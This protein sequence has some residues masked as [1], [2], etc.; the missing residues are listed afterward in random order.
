MKTHLN[1]VM[2]KILLLMGILLI[3][4]PAY[5]LR[6]GTNLVE[7]GDSEA[8]VLHYCGKP[9]MKTKIKKKVMLDGNR[10][11]IT[12]IIQWTYNFGSSDFLYLLNFSGGKLVKIS[13]NGYGY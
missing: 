7:V 2:Q 3:A 11:S 1:K 9:T 5:A 6:C 12:T 10:E 8:K 4:S 13:T